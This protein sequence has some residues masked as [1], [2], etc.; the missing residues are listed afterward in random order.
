M[1][2]CAYAVKDQPS[3]VGEPT[4]EA[5]AGPA[6]VRFQRFSVVPRNGNWSPAR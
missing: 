5:V 1:I 2:R 3:A 4:P 6:S